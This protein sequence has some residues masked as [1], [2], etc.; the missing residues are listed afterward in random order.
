MGSK[1]SRRRWVDLIETFIFMHR[2][3]TQFISEKNRPQ[4]NVTFDYGPHAT[5]SNNSLQ[6]YCYTTWKSQNIDFT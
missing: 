1:E 4:Q 2:N 5:M 6:S 3:S